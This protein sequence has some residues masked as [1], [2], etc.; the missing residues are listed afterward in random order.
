VFVLPVRNSDHKYSHQVEDTLNNSN[1]LFLTFRRE[2]EEMSRKT[3][4][5]EKENASL[6]RKYEAA[7]FERLSG[8]LP[9]SEVY[10]G[11]AEPSKSG[12]K[13]AGSN[14]NKT[15]NVE[16]TWDVPLIPEEGGEEEADTGD[17]NE[18]QG[19]DD[20]TGRSD[21]VLE[22]PDQGLKTESSPSGTAADAEG[23]AG[24]FERQRGRMT[25]GLPAL[26]HN[27]GHGVSK[28]KEVEANKV[29]KDDTKDN[30]VNED[31]LEDE[32][33]K[34]VMSQAAVSR[35]QAVRALRQNNSDIVDAI[36][37]LSF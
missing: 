3:K 23:A 2:M 20:E 37:A 30:V 15:G 13:T 6:R 33:I 36:M 25:S 1:E 8:G 34:L 9:R 29:E 24:K 12:R 22:R 19:S 11:L 10:G 16:L 4:R 28:D 17:K 31:G 5:L 35:K 26:M 18:T 21:S 32:D 27:H 7:Q 14:R